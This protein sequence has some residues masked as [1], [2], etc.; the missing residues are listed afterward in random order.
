M[1]AK[2]LDQFVKD[3]TGTGREDQDARTFW[4]ELLNILGISDLKGTVEFERR[5]AGNGK[6]DALFPDARLLVEMKSYGVDLDKPE[7]RQ[8]HPRDPGR[9]SPALRACP[10]AEREA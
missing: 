2:T 1:E 4:I 8:G 3:W 7:P 9:A 10:A 6:I 5:T